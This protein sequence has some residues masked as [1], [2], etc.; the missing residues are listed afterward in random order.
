M[1]PVGGDVFEVQPP[2]AIGVM[3]AETT[4]RHLCVTVYAFQM[5]KSG[6]PVVG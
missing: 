1:H 6:E 2:L 4:G 3:L 5:L